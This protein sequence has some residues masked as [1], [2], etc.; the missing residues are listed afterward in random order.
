MYRGNGDEPLSFQEAIDRE[1]RSIEKGEL[2]VGDERAGF[3]HD[4]LRQLIAGGKKTRR[5]APRTY[6]M[7]GYY[8]T[9]IR[10]YLEYF[11]H[12]NVL[13]VD[14]SR[15]RSDREAV[16]QEIFDFVGAT[17]PFEDSPTEDYHIG[18]KSE[19]LTDFKGQ[20]GA[21]VKYLPGGMRNRLKKA[22][23]A[24]DRFAPEG[25]IEGAV[26]SQLYEHYEV[27]DMRLADLMGWRRVPWREREP[28]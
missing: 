13:V 8:E 6:V 22:V 23:K 27:P 25:G 18:L 28:V 7:R 19:L 21:I 16:L 3:W 14:Q 9:H 1:I 2:P 26:A 15:L 17:P 4:Y 10:R 20:L 12:S 5:N 24:I 11:E